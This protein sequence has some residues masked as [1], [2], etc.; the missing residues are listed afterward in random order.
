[1]SVAFHL[2]NWEACHELHVQF[3]QKFLP[4]HAE[5]T[6]VSITLYKALTRHLLYMESLHKK[7]TSRIALLK[8]MAG[9]GRKVNTNTLC[10]ITLA[11]VH[12]TTEYYTPVECRSAHTHLINSTINGALRIVTGC[13]CPTKFWLASNIL[14]PAMKELL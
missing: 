9:S 12:S 1:M 10:M 13:L 7:L 4:F 8:Q 11:L 2:N 6:Y 5:P 3:N 14:D